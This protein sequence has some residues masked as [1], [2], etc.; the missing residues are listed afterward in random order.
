M[1]FIIFVL[2]EKYVFRPKQQEKLEQVNEKFNKATYINKIKRFYK[3]FFSP[4]LFHNN[5][6]WN[7]FYDKILLLQYNKWL[8]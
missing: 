7:A 6:L 2:P 8:S 5:N 4:F 3:L 1:F